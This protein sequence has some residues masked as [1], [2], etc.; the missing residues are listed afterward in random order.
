[1]LHYVLLSKGNL[2]FEKKRRILYDF[3]RYSTHVQKRVV[4][5]TMGLHKF[6][7]ISKILDADFVEVMIEPENKQH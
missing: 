3:P 4:M 6:I 5:V 2:E 7:K 1:M